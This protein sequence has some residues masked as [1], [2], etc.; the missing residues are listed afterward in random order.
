MQGTGRRRGNRFEGNPAIDYFDILTFP[1]DK[2]RPP[3]RDVEKIYPRIRANILK[4]I[5]RAN[6]AGDMEGIESLEDDVKNLEEAYSFFTQDDPGNT[7]FDRW[8]ANRATQDQHGLDSRDY[9]QNRDN[10]RRIL[11]PDTGNPRISDPPLST[12]GDVFKG[13]AN[14]NG[15]VQRKVAFKPPSNVDDFDMD[16][17]PLE[18]PSEGRGQ[19]DEGSF[20]RD[21]YTG[22]IHPEIWRRLGV[23]P[24]PQEI[25]DAYARHP[26]L[27]SNELDFEY[28]TAEELAISSPSLPHSKDNVS[29]GQSLEIELGNTEERLSKEYKASQQDRQMD[30]NLRRRLSTWRALINQGNLTNQQLLRRMEEEEEANHQR[31]LDAEVEAV[32]NAPRVPWQETARRRALEAQ[33][34][35]REQRR[36]LFET[37]NKTDLADQLLRLDLETPG[38]VKSADYSYWAP[39]IVAP[40]FAEAKLLDD[41]TNI[42]WR[43]LDV[44]WPASPTAEQITRSNQRLRDIEDRSDAAR[45]NGELIDEG[46]PPEGEKREMTDEELR[47]R[48]KETEPNTW[49]KSYQRSW[50]SRLLFG[51]HERLVDGREIALVPKKHRFKPSVYK[52]NDNMELEHVCSPGESYYEHLYFSNDTFIWPESLPKPPGRSARDRWIMKLQETDALRHRDGLPQL[53]PIPGITPTNLPYDPDLF[54]LPPKPQPTPTPSARTDQTASEQPLEEGR[55]MTRRPRFEDFVRDMQEQGRQMNRNESENQPSGAGNGD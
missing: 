13:A 19:R 14:R 42:N 31:D 29:H 11:F 53:D 22:R 24:P 23:S 3:K 1:E 36:A 51:E 34:S 39:G 27:T 15:R 52:L 25:Q 41:E 49:W 32:G 46:D 17:V 10:S 21:Q 8:V 44:E 45:R 48:V 55:D 26:R 30:N 9:P 4:E 7:L 12:D 54:N 2:G 50:F 35:Y 5:R 28:S 37:K 33:K 6:E 18:S 20:P 38:W 16:E 43:A 47:V 40:E